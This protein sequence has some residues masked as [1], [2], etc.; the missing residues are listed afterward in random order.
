MDYRLNVKYT[1]TIN[2]PVYNIGGYVYDHGSSKG[3]LFFYLFF[4]FFSKGFLDIP[5]VPY[6]EEKKNW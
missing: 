1:K 5:K 6:M 3:F 2:L 4:N